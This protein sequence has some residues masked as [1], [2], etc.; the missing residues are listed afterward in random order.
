MNVVEI[1][2]M[3]D[4]EMKEALDSVHKEM[5]NLRFQRSVGQ[6]SDPNRLRFLRQDHAR[7]LTIRRE[8]ELWAEYEAS[9]AAPETEQE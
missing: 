6:L 1:R 7:L 3:S 4:V 8:R 5:F 2:A 9:G